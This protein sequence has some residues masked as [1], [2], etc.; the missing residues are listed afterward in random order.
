MVNYST[1]DN[2][3]APMWSTVPSTTQ[4]YALVRSSGL[5]FH[6]SLPSS[7]SQVQGTGVVC[8]SLAHCASGGHA[9]PGAERRSPLVEHDP[10]EEGAT[11][12]SHNC[13]SHRPA[14]LTC[15]KKTRNSPPMNCS[16]SWVGIL[17]SRG[18][19]GR[20]RIL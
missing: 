6:D 18:R 15:Q 16:W 17:G 9:L 4:E 20:I 1:V 3:G 19:W 13:T 8:Q 12:W 5:L 11:P 10:Q 7:V 14:L 2:G